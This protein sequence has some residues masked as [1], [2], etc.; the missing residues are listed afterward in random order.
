MPSEMANNDRKQITRFIAPRCGAM[1]Y[2]QYF[3]SLFTFYEGIP[4]KS[5]KN[6][7]L[8]LKGQMKKC[9]QLFDNYE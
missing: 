6:H 2:V 8:T 7:I 5:T 1:C 3:L 4:Q 9:N